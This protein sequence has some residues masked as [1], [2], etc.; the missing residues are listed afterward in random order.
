MLVVILLGCSG[1]LC[2]ENARYVY[3]VYI[4][5]WYGGWIRSFYGFGFYSP[6]VEVGLLLAV[7]GE[8]GGGS[9]AGGGIAFEH[10]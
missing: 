3:I 4:L 10:F 2:P 6:A 8:H 9:G 1:D 5:R 7:L